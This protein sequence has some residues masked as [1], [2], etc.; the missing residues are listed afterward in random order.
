MAHLNV[1]EKFSVYISLTRNRI[2]IIK[3]MY[4]FQLSNSQGIN[5]KYAIIY[6]PG[7]HN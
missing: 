2:Q 1:K 6:Y 3:F 7:T 5:A 4:D